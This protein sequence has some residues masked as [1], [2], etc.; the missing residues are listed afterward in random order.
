M[1][2]YVTILKMHGVIKTRQIA[3]LAVEL[4]QI[5]TMQL[6]LNLVDVAQK[7]EYVTI[8]KMRGVIKT[9]QIANLVVEFGHEYSFECMCLDTL[10]IISVKHVESPPTFFCY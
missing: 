9:R 1:G 6:S 3:N 8:L 7:M 2:E 4:G 5:P 10:R